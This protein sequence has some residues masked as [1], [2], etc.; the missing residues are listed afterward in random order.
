LFI[1][2]NRQRWLDR[3]PGIESD[4]FILDLEDSVPDADRPQARKM[5]RAAI[6]Q[7]GAGDVIFVRVN[8][9]ETNMTFDDLEAVVAPGLHGVYLPKV[10]GP[11][12]VIVLDGALTWFEKR[13]GVPEG[14]VIINPLLEYASSKR[15]AYEVAMASPRVAYMGGGTAR[16]GDGARALGIEWTPKGLETLFFRSKT[17]LD[18]RAAGIKFPMSGLWLDLHDLDGLRAFCLQTRQ[19]G[20]TGMMA[21]YPGHLP[22]INETFSPSA[23]EIAYWEELIA[24]LEEAAKNGTTAITFRGE[25]V[26][27]AMVKT[28]RDHLALAERL[29]RSGS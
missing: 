16:G 3:I 25:M 20:Y 29:Q 19:L 9:V 4:S 8:G 11:E 1:P 22:I 2:A 13:A 26:D 27:T 23:D 6:D 18:M 21:I 10:R 17:L 28:G 12:D 5:A 7:H 24:L 15:V 14:S